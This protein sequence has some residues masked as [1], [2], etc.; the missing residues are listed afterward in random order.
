MMREMISRTMKKHVKFGYISAGSWFASAENKRFIEKK[1]KTFI[2]EIN[3]NRLAGGKRTGEGKG[4]FY[5]DRSD[6]NAG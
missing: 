5:Q 2:L 6:G 4:S 1:G 3:D